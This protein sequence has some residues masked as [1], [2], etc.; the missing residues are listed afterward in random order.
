V[1]LKA[2][3]EGNNCIC[4]LDFNI[5]EAFDVGP[6]CAKIKYN[7]QEEGVTL[8]LTLGKSFSKSSVIKPSK[9]EEP[10]C[11]SM[12]G[13]L[14]KMCAKFNGL[15]PSQSNGY[16]G[17]LTMQPKLFGEVPINFDFPCFDLNKQEIRM[18]EAPK[19]SESA[20]EDDEKEESAEPGTS[21]GDETIGGFK[22][23][24]I[25][26][27]VSQTADQGIK[28]ISEL[29]GINEEEK[30][31]TSQKVESKEVP[32]TPKNVTKTK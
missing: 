22:V 23:E 14:A 17:C 28:I 24:D 31:P 8:N 11:L 20:E 6:A 16:V 32:E 2:S 15:V 26:N 3:A 10:V 12:L 27:V 5:S 18:I 1:C 13:G 9:P 4:C 21:G 19:K 7:S 29:F 25:L 30:E